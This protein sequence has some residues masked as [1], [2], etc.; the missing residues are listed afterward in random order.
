MEL[1]TKTEI[2]Q[3]LKVTTIT[4]DRYEKKGMPVLRPAGGDPRYDFE[5]IIEWMKT[6][7]EDKEG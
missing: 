5:A 6:K 3:K 7:P 1:L 2:A 4:I